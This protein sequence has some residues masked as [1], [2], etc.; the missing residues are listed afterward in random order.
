MFPTIN[1][2]EPILAEKR[3]ELYHQIWVQIFVNFG[4]F[5]NLDAKFRRWSMM[6]YF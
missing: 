3:I 4:K 1:D 2:V 5:R 6:Y